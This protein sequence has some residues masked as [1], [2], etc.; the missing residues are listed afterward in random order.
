MRN[1]TVTFARAV[2]LA[3]A[4]VM[5]AFAATPQEMLSDYEAAA[6]RDEAGFKVSAA[7]GAAFFRKEHATA[8]EA[9][10]ACAGCHGADPRQ[11]GRTRANKSIEPLAPVANRARFVDPAK[12]E[13]WFGRNCG[14]VLGRPCT[15][16][17]KA[18][19]IAW[20]INLKI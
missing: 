7:R 17:E 6:R 10:A 4:L 12:T 19:F 16:A 2:S 9:A 20:L 8:K 14:D 5:P 1:F 11:S 3:L 13:K 18:D 15:A